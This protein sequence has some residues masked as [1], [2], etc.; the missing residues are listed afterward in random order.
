ME[1]YQSNFNVNSY[2]IRVFEH[3]GCSQ[4]TV[5]RACNPEINSQSSPKE[6]YFFAQIYEYEVSTKRKLRGVKMW[7]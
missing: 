4:N 6:I 7:N 5:H 2:D 3:F 1:T